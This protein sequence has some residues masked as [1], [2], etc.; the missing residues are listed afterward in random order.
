VVLVR[1]GERELERRPVVV[2]ASVDSQLEIAS[3][4]N[5]GEE[6]VVEGAVLLD[7]ELDRLL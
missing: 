1:R 2:G 4:L 7:G 5:E 3:G 6:V